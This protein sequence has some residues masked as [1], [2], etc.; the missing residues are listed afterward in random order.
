MRQNRRWKKQPHYV[1][2]QEV[3]KVGEGK[4]V[5]QEIQEYRSP[6]Y[7][8][9]IYDSKGL[10]LE[11]FEKIKEETIS[12]IQNKNSSENADDYINLVWLCIA[13]TSARFED[14]EINL[15]KELTKLPAVGVIVVLTKCDSPNDPNTKE[16]LEKAKEAFQGCTVLRTRVGQ[17]DH[18]DDGNLIQTKP[19]W[20]IDG[21][22]GLI[23]TSLKLIPDSQKQAF[24]AALNVQHQRALQ[25]KKE[26]A[27]KIVNW[28]TGAAAVVSA[29]PIP[30][31]GS[32]AIMGVQAAMIAKISSLFGMNIMEGNLKSILSVILGPLLAK[33]LGKTVIAGFLKMIPG[34]GSV[35][36][37]LIDA[38]VAGSLTKLI[39]NL[40]IEVIMGFAEKN[41]ELSPDDVFEEFGERLRLLPKK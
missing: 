4:P 17:E 40:Y 32:V 35:A 7:P 33:F 26:A 37:G 8:L 39:G 24:T 30:F 29:T 28:A 22:G 2:G 1:F 9:T 15:A 21:E 6:K 38:G 12:F 34:I 13:R 11:E 31:S 10:E 27:Q 18:D 5:T 16:F 36:G 23:D 3:A 41:K 19:D 25:A 14:A 20:G